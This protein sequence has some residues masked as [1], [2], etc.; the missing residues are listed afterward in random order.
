MDKDE[1]MDEIYKMQVDFDI[2]KKE[3]N[4]ILKPHFEKPFSWRY[5]SSMPTDMLLDELKEEV[6]TFARDN[7]N[8]VMK[9]YRLKK[10]REL[11]HSNVRIVAEGDSWFQH[12]FLDDIVDCLFKD[13]YAVYSFS[14]AGDS[15]VNMA[16]E[17]EFLDAIKTENPVC[18]LFSGGGNDILD[19]SFLKELIDSSLPGLI[20]EELYKEKLISL[21]QAISTIIDKINEVKNGLPI[22]MHGYDYI[23]P[24]H[25]ASF[26][27]VYPVLIQKGIDDSL[28]Q[29]QIIK[30]LIDKYNDLLWELSVKFKGQFHYID[31]RGTL[32]TENQ[33]YDEIHPAN[34]SFRKITDKFTTKLLSI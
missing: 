29:K 8:R 27:W 16:F 31:L 17:S 10:Y 26:T 1:I 12:P 14:E 30:K 6:Y 7:I 22:L 2:E 13:K 33:W 28:E 32:V 18:F 34:M 11:K 3:F 19:G 9:S 25:N 20:N 15:L 4:K 23:I 21:E 24:R 5:D